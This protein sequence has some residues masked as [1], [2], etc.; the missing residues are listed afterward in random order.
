MP[1]STDLDAAFEDLA[2]RASSADGPP[3]A[4]AAIRT[5][6]QRRRRSVGGLAVVVALTA[7]AVLAPQLLPDTLPG[8]TTEV[9]PD[10]ARFDAPALEEAADGW[11]E[12]WAEEDV[13]DG[14]WGWSGCSMIGAGLGVEPAARTV[15]T[16]ELFTRDA[17][18]RTQVYTF[19]D[20]GALDSAWDDF[21]QHL[22]AC[23][24]M[25]PDEPGG[26][27][28]DGTAV[29]HYGVL[30]DSA[31]DPGLRVTDVWMARTGSRFAYLET[32]SDA[33]AAPPDVAEEVSRALLAGTSSGWTATTRPARAEDP[34]PAP[35]LPSYDPE[36]L[37]AALDGWLAT[38][39]ADALGAPAHPCLT[40]YEWD[41]EAMSSSSHP[42]GSFVRISGHVRGR[43]RAA[44][45]IRDQVE[46]L[47]TC[48]EGVRT[49]RDLPGGV[50][51]YAYDLGGD[52]GHGSIWLAHNDDRAMV[53]TVHGGRS[54]VPAR[55][56]EVVGEWM[57]SVLDLRWPEE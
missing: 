34:P 39:P 20:A 1:E 49:R 23:T 56:T 12:G 25:D 32:I 53:V 9:V 57:R 36:P 17:L 52:G 28:T 47:E 19:D 10:P 42:R 16:T 7:G 2:R 11:I 54:S 24:E 31:T 35:A 13:T 5:V 30:D 8:P 27:Y 51:T 21:R 22:D 15:G 14:S 4:E 38:R 43:E 33:G 46:G 50:I 3:G 48:T 29:A 55:S 6:R 44:R 40:W 37:A 18:A 45:V 41:D 26:G